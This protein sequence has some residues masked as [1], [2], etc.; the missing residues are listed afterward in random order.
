MGH[1][2]NAC[3]VLWCQDCAWQHSAQ[4][5]LTI[6]DY[7]AL[8]RGVAI[9]EAHYDYFAPGRLGDPLVLATWLT[10]CDNKIRLQR[11]FQI[12]HRLSGATLL[13]GCWDLICINV[14]T[15]KPARFPQPFI[16]TYGTAVIRG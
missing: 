10:D 2:N 4:L 9:R 13:R 6:N 12:V 3:Y 5:G 14:E 16:D 8:N 11:R 1:V 7:Q 15:G